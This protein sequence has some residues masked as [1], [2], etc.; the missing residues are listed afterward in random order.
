MCVCSDEQGP[1]TQISGT[2]VATWLTQASV[3]GGTPLEHTASAHES[4]QRAQCLRAAWTLDLWKHP[5]PNLWKNLV[6]KGEKDLST[7]PG[8][9]SL[10]ANAEDTSSIPGQGTKILYDLW[11]KPK[12]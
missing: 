12:T 9:N 10:P 5:P 6:N 8:V 7:V 1:L 11:P 2:I 4:W 3:P